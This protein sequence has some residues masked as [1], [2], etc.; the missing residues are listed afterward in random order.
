MFSSKKI[1]KGY[2]SLEILIILSIALSIST[3]ALL[4]TSRSYD[5]TNLEEQA[6]LNEMSAF[7]EK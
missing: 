7:N 4:R 3:M 5:L 2:V 6:I 1:R